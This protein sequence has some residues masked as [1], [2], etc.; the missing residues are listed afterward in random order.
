M[1][2]KNCTQKLAPPETASDIGEGN[3]WFRPYARSADGDLEQ[4]SML[5]L[6]AD[7]A[8]E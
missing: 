1:T 2:R 4:P 3:R 8:R 7:R 6:V 5:H